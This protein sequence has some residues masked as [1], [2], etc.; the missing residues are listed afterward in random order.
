LHWN[1][2]K[3]NQQWLP[4]LNALK[5]KLTTGLK[6][7]RRGRAGPKPARGGAQARTDDWFLYFAC[8]VAMRNIECRKP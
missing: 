1:A 6:V 8:D 2:R 7:R 3:I 4:P 5:Y